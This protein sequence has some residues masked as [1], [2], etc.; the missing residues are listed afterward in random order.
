MSKKD[1]TVTQINPLAQSNKVSNQTV[2]NPS[3]AGDNS[4]TQ[5]NT[6]ALQETQINSSLQDDSGELTSVNP[7]LI[8]HGVTV[9]IGTELCGK[10]R[11]SKLLSTGTGEAVLYIC[12]YQDKD[13][14]AKIYKRAAAI[15][16]DIIEA[17][18]KLDSPNIARLYD[19]G[20]WQ[21]MPFEIIPYYPNGSLQGKTYSF[22][23][24][25]DNII[26]NLNE[27]LRVL[28]KSGIIHKD[29]KPSNI[30]LCNDAKTV[31][32]IDFGISSIRDNGQTVL[33]TQT[34]MTPDYSAPETFRSLFLE[35]S[36]YYS[37]GITIYEL[38]CGHVPYQ[39]VDKDTLEKYVAIQRIPIPKDFPEKLQQLILG[40]TYNDI[41]NR[42]DKRNPNRRWTYDEVRRWCKGEEVLVP[43]AGSNGADSQV[44][45]INNLSPI[46]S[47]TFMYH[48]Y[49][50]L[51]S[52]V[53]AL[54][55]D[56]KNGKKRLYRST[57]SDYF[58]QFNQD[59]ANMCLDA[60]EIV[61]AHPDREDVEYFK[62]LYRLYPTLQCF[63]WGA[64]YY[65]D[66]HSVGQTILKSVS[67]QDK[68]TVKII[69]E[70]VKNKLF[71]I[72]ES[73]VHHDNQDII[74]Q[75]SAIEDRHNT[76]LRNKDNRIADSQ[77]YLLGYY[78]S[79]Q[80][81]LVTA[82]GRFTDIKSLTSFLL[83]KIEA[84]VDIDKYADE[85]MIYVDGGTDNP[86]DNE[87]P[88]A[89]FYA[90]LIVQ[91]KGTIVK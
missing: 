89:Q 20:I 54:S 19:S 32:I 60:E 31:A 86:I 11:V 45:S 13:Y 55:R 80:H 17:L 42:K 81:D 27:G 76:A 74:R 26:P 37:L 39:G 34:G 4:V 3:V 67:M 8:N 24:L 16:P 57:L 38:F 1:S 5:I 50:D 73:V 66:M 72:R 28:H 48:K 61:N 70:M 40:L 18:K 44:A 23:E 43:G 78:Y 30:M 68:D 51:Y 62:T 35:E 14:V 91:G 2:V 85:L 63:S 82:F 56:W 58:R 47:I 87:I 79:G 6:D 10:Y 53:N 46:P 88:N 64:Y 75:I 29:L 83:S 25:R 90:W 77:L 71:S 49:K 36:D 7:L 22:E 65:N 52:L 59:L 84:N 33:Q 9:P 15:K 12:S 69:R 21:G 41:T